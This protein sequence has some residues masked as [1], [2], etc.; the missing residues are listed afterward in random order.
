MRK[1]GM[2]LLAALLLAGCG[3][4]QTMETLGNVD[5]ISPS[6]ATHAGVLL[7]LPSEAALETS[8][9]D[10]GVSVYLCNGYTMVLQ[11]FSSGD[12]TATI[13]SLSGFSPDALTL[14]ESDADHYKRY[15]WVWTAVA[16]EGEMV[17]RGAVLDDGDYHYTLCVM[18]QATDAGEVTE[19]WNVLFG[20]FCLET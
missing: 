3:A 5:H 18:A 7:E 15:D 6:L 16:E 8:A 11:T 9:E 2:I 19:S 13:R 17:C 12:L 1:I 14:M 4:E 10:G 20:S